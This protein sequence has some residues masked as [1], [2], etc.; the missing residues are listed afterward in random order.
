VKNLIHTWIVFLNSYIFCIFC[1]SAA[2]PWPGH[3]TVPSQGGNPLGVLQV[4]GL[5]FVL[6]LSLYQVHHGTDEPLMLSLFSSKT[7]FWGFSCFVFVYFDRVL[8][9]YRGLK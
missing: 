7:F 2:H 9:V 3:G 4:S 1:P 8:T 5:K 6:A